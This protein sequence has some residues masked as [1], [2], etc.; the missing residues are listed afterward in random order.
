MS[1]QTKR[2]IRW[3]SNFEKEE[4]WLNQMS[5]Q[6]W[7]LIHVNSFGVYIFAHGV[8]QN[9]VY[10]IDYRA[11]KNQ[12]KFEEYATLFVDSGWNFIAG[13]KNTGSQ[14]FCTMNPQENSD[15]FSD[16]CSRAGRYKRLSQQFC[17]LT[18]AFFMSTFTF[19]T[20]STQKPFDFTYLTPGLWEKTGIHFWMSF[21]FETPFVLL[22]GGSP[23]VSIAFLLFC[24]IYAIKAKICY[25]Q[26][27]K[28]T[29]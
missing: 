7:H 1:K 21:L 23:V 20:S 13:G 29:F 5:M 12:N 2:I 15:I 27:M 8:P 3:Y 14:Y 24:I 17:L 26:A 18:F 25:D 16:K 6:G 22:R 19:L 9:I 10:R 4:K 28:D 11:F